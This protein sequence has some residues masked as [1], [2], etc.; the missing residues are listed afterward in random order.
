MYPEQP[1]DVFRYGCWLVL[2]RGR[3]QVTADSQRRDGKED[4]QPQPH[5]LARAGQG[6]GHR[7]SILYG[8]PRVV[9]AASTGP[10]RQLRMTDR[11]AFAAHRGLIRRCHVP[12]A[13][14]RDMLDQEVSIR[15]AMR[16]QPHVVRRAALR[17][18]VASCALILGALA[19]RGTAPPPA[20]TVSFVGD[21]RATAGRVAVNLEV[22]A[23]SFTAVTFTEPGTGVRAAQENSLRPANARGGASAAWV[24]FTGERHGGGARRAG[25]GGRGACGLY[26]VLHDGRG[27]RCVR[28]RGDGW[29]IGM[30]WRS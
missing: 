21:Y 22:T 14:R 7:D 11:M 13:S 2:L 4:R 24:V 1:G 19:C 3:E 16:V 30:S 12:S 6:G 25:S 9:T 10:F 20:A 29:H 26:A 23:D 18:A 5:D 27:G 17:V 15:R 8:G 28:G